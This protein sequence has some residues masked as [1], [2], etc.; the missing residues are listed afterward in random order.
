MKPKI[1]LIA[2]VAPGGII[3]FK[4]R[5][6]WHLPRD[7]RYFKRTTLGHPII[8][9]R[10]TFESLECKA[11]PKR[12]NII[13]TR[14]YSY[15]A[16]GCDV[17]YSLNEAINIAGNVRKIFII[18]GGEIYASA[19][20]L[21]DEIHLTKIEDKNQTEKLS[22]LFKGDTFFPKIN[23]SEWK[24]IHTGRRFLAKKKIQDLA[25]NKDN[26]IYFQRFIYTRASKDN[27]KLTK[28]V[29]SL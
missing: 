7:L 24:I 13:I 5:M 4:N 6:P 27:A 29:P 14:N 17:V 2:A 25:Q 11:L 21:A 18:G 8:M 16:P 23:T 20:S 15:I 26:W 19:I 3:G 12:R 22:T 1:L 9:G 10:K 28:K